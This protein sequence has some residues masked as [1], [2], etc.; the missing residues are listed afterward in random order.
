MISELPVNY[1]IGAIHIADTTD[2]KVKNRAL[3]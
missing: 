3:C 1:Q 2:G